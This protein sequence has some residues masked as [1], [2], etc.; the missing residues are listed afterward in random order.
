MKRR[1]PQSPTPIS[2][3]RLQYLFEIAFLF[4]RSAPTSYEMGHR[5][6][7]QQRKRSES[8]S[9][10]C[11]MQSVSRLC[12]RAPANGPAAAAAPAPHHRSQCSTSHNRQ[13]VP[14]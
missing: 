7:A 6:R 4:L 1:P 10:G 2:A 11:R 13:Q 14:Q 9:T 8:K 3:C 5:P 12:D